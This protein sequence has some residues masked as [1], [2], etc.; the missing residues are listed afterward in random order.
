LLIPLHNLTSNEYSIEFEE[1]IVWVE[2]TKLSPTPAW[3]TDRRGERQ[4]S[5]VDF[6]KRKLDRRT[7]ADY[8]DHA[9]AGK[10]IAS[11]IPQEVA[12]ASVEAERATRD[13]R[14]LR[15][16]GALGVVLGVV[17][18]ALAAIWPV[19]SVI[20]DT[21]GRLDDL[22]K[23]NAQLRQDIHNLKETPGKQ[24]RRGSAPAAPSP[25]GNRHLALGRRTG[26]LSGSAAP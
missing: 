20:S 26:D 14:N 4:S 3:K 13:V 22:S 11:S 12:Q 17:A 9:N 16:F 10:P 5:F 18:V 1:P 6:P 25:F 15:R 19:V 23:T 24:S 7:P 21:N 2:F 8:L